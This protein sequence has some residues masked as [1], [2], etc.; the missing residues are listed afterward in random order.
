M[1]NMAILAGNTR[2]GTDT[3]RFGPV[4]AR[5]HC[6]EG[7]AVR[8]EKGYQVEDAEWRRIVA[9]NGLGWTIRHYCETGMK[10]LVR[11]RIHYM[12]RQDS[13]GQHRW[14]GLFSTLSV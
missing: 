5:L 12:K 9:F 3:T 13:E 10:R 2:A 6:S 14:R 7:R 11:G 8:D 1:Q 4:T